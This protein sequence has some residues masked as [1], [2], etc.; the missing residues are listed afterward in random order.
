MGSKVDIDNLN[1]EDTKLYRLL[2]DKRNHLATSN[3]VIPYTVATQ[4]ALAEMAKRKPKTI[5]ELI[6]CN[7]M[8]WLLPF[9]IYNRVFF[10][11]R[12][13][14]KGRLEGSAVSLCRLS[15]SC[16]DCP[17]KYPPTFHL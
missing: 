8:L 1:E 6:S 15:E 9:F 13:L 17:P 14:R 10:Q 11:W 4:V 12:A 5:P 2:L 16:V 3:G 7:C